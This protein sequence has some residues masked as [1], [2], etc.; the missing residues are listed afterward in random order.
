MTETTAGASINYKGN[1]KIG[2]VG[3][4]L[5]GGTELKT[6][7]DGEIMFRGRHVMKV[8]Y[9]N[10]GATAEVMDGEWLRSGDIGKID[11]DGFVTITG[12]KKE[13][14][15]SSGGK[16][17]APLVIEETMK[18]IPLVSQCFLVG[19]ARKF[20]SALLTLDVSALL[21]D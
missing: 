21:R 2:S 9:N 8:Y 11:S 5:P 4:T 20:C 12:R 7:T 17:I 1:V 14:Y 19:D 13:L 3:R 16:N 15:V 10:P 18:A 6:D